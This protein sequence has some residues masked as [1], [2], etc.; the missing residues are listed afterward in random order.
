MLLWRGAVVDF[1]VCKR[2]GCKN[3]IK[4]YMLSK[5]QGLTLK[6]TVYSRKNSELDRKDYS[7]K[8]H[9]LSFER[10]RLKHGNSVY[11]DSYYNSFKLASSLL[12]GYN[13]CYTSII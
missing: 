3:M 9:T 10:E 8:N 6:L 2:Q 13:T 11:I 4:Y 12:S 5:P 1:P 7:K